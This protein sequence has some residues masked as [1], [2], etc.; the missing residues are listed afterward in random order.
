MNKFVA[1]TAAG[2]ALATG[3]VAV[4]TLTPLG[5]AFAQDGSQTQAPAGTD[6]AGGRGIVRA[7][8][9]AAVKDAAGVIG[10]TPQ[11]LMTQLKA[12]SSIA[13]VATSKG[14]DPQAVITKLST[15]ANARIDQLVTEGKITQERADQAKAKTTDR[16]TK[17]VNRKFD[18]SHRP[19]G[20]KPT[21]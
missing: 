5:T 17:L 21:K 20:T 7:V 19:S 12:G 15:D 3:S 16:V 18:G 13:E 1:T 4:A 2:L 14:V 11:E 9:K 10:I 6:H 8:A